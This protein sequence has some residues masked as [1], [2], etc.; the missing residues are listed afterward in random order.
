MIS[1]ATSLRI[2]DEMLQLLQNGRIKS[3][4]K[5]FG[6]CLILSWVHSRRFV[7]M[8]ATIC[9][10][11]EPNDARVKSHRIK[12]MENLRSNARLSGRG[13]RALRAG[14]KIRLKPFVS[15]SSTADLLLHR[16]AFDHI[17]TH[18][19][20]SRDE[21]RQ[22]KA[23]CLQ[24]CLIRGRGTLAP[25]CYNQHRKIKKLADVQFVPGAIPQ[26]IGVYQFEELADDS[27]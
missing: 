5:E 8:Q 3:T 22:R 10:R 17:C 9:I 12:P 11:I 19:R 1:D 24:K 16:G 13:Q 25:S 2:N 14:P 6:L 21:L 7:Y 20:R 27:F 26:S 4:D 18:D 15:R 23:S